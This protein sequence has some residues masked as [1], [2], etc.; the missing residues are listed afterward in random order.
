MVTYPD[1]PYLG[2][3]IEYTCNFCVIKSLSP[4]VGFKGGDGEPSND[5]GSHIYTVQFECSACGK[6]NG[7]IRPVFYNLYSKGVIV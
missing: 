7:R 1:K 3:S 2:L 6:I 5:D 4:I